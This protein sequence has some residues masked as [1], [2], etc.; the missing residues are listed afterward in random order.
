MTSSA[1]G[2]DA[3]RRRRRKGSGVGWLHSLWRRSIRL[4]VAAGILAQ[5]VGCTRPF[6]RKQ[7]DEQVAEIL[8]QKNKYPT[9]A[10]QNWHVYPDPRSRFGDPTNPDFPPKPPDDPAAINLAP[11]P[12]KPR[13]A[14][15]AH[16]EGT[17]YLE[18]LS[19][20]DQENRAKLARQ[21]EEEKRQE[22]KEQRAA[23]QEL[24]APL[25]R[26]ADGTPTLHLRPRF[27]ERPAGA[28][29][30]PLKLCLKPRLQGIRPVAA[31]QPAAG[32]GSPRL[33]LK[34]RLQGIQLASA[35]QPA[36]PEALPY[37]E[38]PGRMTEEI[39]SADAASVANA[40][41][42][43]DMTGQRAYLLSLDQAAELA[44]F[45][46]REFQDQRENLY[47]AALAV[48]QERF[49]FI[50]QP[51]VAQQAIRNYAGS[52]TP[53]GKLN[54]W[55]LN[56]GVGLSKVLPT[57]ALL[58]LN[59]ANQ[60]VFDFLNPK[61]TISTSTLNFEAIQ[62]LLRGGGRAVALEPLTL[63]ER[64][65]LY[66]IRTFARF[67]KQLYVEIASANGGSIFGG[68]FQPTGVLSANNFNPAF[69]FGSTGIIP[70]VIP[71]FTTTLGGPQATAGPAGNLAL[72]PA[73]TPSPAGYLNTMLEKIQV[74]IDQENIAVLTGILRRFQGLLEGDIVGPLQVQ[75]V[76]Q[77]LLNGRTT[78]LN[79]QA[80][81]LAAIDLFKVEL[82]LPMNVTIEPDESALR[83]LINQFR[84]SRAII[85]HE[86]AA[87]TESA[88]FGSLENAPRARAGLLRLFE[89]SALSR[90]TRFAQT[91][92]ARW[93]RWRGDNW[94]EEKIQAELK[95]L[96]EK[97]RK[98]LDQQA[99]LER[100]GKK[101][102]RAAA[103][104]LA[105]VQADYDLGNLELSLRV[106]ERNYVDMGKPKKPPTPAAERLRVTRFQTILGFW[107]RLMV[108]PRN[109]QR[110]KV[111][112][113]WPEP[114]RV[115]ISQVD[116]VKT[117]LTNAQLTAAN[118]AMTNRFDL[119]NVR[120]QVVDGWRQL[121]VFANALLG[122]FNVEY[123]LAANT[124]L[125]VAQPLN[126]G[127]SG[128]AHQ[129][130]IN[131]QL[132]LV[133][134]TER[135][136]YRA[137]IIAY[138]RQRRVLQEAEDLAAQAVRNEVYT[139]RQYYETYRV[140]QRLLDLAYLT[141]DNALEALVAP[142]APGRTASDGP[143]AL[144]QQLLASQR[145]LPQAQLAVLAAWIN[146]LN[147]RL[148][149]YRDLEYMP[150]SPQGSWIDQVAECDCPPPG[151]GAGVPR[152]QTPTSQEDRWLPAPDPARQPGS[153]PR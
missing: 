13:K 46:S 56:T 6:Y 39:A 75:N 117:D 44:T 36:T 69:G 113:T 18:L 38:Q 101:L 41:S 100:M 22:Q 138:Q 122:V 91:I 79:D 4:G 107:Q 67:R 102:P 129:L 14:G 10:I 58:L 104:E 16:V 89:T 145:S 150:L 5:A 27:Q 86:Q 35:A 59:F 40:R 84:K 81:Y 135:N 30:Q 153:P 109:E 141:I 68:A 116:L 82:G 66:Q 60:T 25:T 64:N 134:I 114:P 54:N 108:E 149:L 77:Q 142:T 12:Q 103:A 71:N 21:E 97:V 131:W 23:L 99:D 55:A 96:R 80:Q 137:A 98:L 87:L 95:A 83:P 20:W 132:P 47:L 49:S 112:A 8:G 37:P 43:V 53:T 2:P 31:A 34:P 93:N 19:Q 85:E 24:E 110:A 105:R 57:G 9:W 7:A 50:A 11:N 1:K 136:A 62:P 3:A 148:Q 152:E 126:I 125:G 88:T 33:S 63:A 70:G 48:T 61:K 146:Y 119:M 130:I 73:I 147:A 128:T 42:L 120:G 144:T 133:R 74:Y 28:E 29:P 15:I 90:G 151:E 111:A 72:T 118:Y 45:N 76:E 127:G 65:L 121:R 26:A 123:H 140:Q 78:L 52:G 17:A 106:Y 94:T 32:P 115:C 139:L 143:A 51:F 124:P 92:R